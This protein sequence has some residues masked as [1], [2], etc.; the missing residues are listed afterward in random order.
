MRKVMCAVLLALAIPV[1]ATSQ[2]Q[3]QGPER[4][5][6]LEQEVRARFLGM[7]A[8]RLELDSA[9]RGRLRG[10][11]ED[12]ARARREL[13][14]ES[15][16]LRQRLVAAA[17]DE[18]TPSSTFEALLRD[19]E[20]LTQREH[21]LERREQERLAE[22]LT[23]RQRAHFLMMRMRLNEQVRELRGRRPPR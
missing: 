4:R 15:L 16:A 1:G 9:Q 7:A 22:F 17:Q 21:A 6:R 11:L 12:G 8:R 3:G 19:M 2:G 14:R 20:A 18:T 10:V 5:D 13:A 23:P